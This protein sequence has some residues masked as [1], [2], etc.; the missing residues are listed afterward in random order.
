M[1]RGIAGLLGCFTLTLGLTL[2]CLSQQSHPKPLPTAEQVLARFVQAVGGT[3]AHDSIKTSFSKGTLVDWD[4]DRIHVEKYSKLPDKE[5][6]IEHK[7]VELRQGYD[8]K[9][10]WVKE[11][12]HKPKQV[13]NWPK[14]EV[15][16][17]DIVHWSDKFTKTDFR[18]EVDILNRQAYV[19]AVV[20]RRPAT[21]YFDQQTGLLLRKDTSFDRPV[22]TYYSN[23]LET[24]GARLPWHIENVVR[25]TGK[26]YVS[27]VTEVKVNVPLDDAIFAMPPP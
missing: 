20:G 16:F 3:T 7:S 4:G 12:N 14:D 2:P 27:D 21:L 8:G 6:M 18:G 13:K 17:E 23:Y 22:E 24:E 5:L 10:R 19:V 25:P 11:G 26:K 9:V 1:Q 15:N